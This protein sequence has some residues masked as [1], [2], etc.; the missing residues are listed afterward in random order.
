M[1]TRA[2]VAKFATAD[3]LLLK[4]TE[5]EVGDPEPAAH[6]K[7]KLVSILVDKTSGVK[8]LAQE[9]TVPVVEKVA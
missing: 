6:V 7:V 3:W 8:L 1:A 4:N 5:Y 9:G 2:D